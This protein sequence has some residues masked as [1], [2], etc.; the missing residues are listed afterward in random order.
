MEKIKNYEELYAE[1]YDKCEELVEENIQLKEKVSTLEAELLHTERDA[2][3][4][5]AQ[6][7]IIH[8]IFG[9]E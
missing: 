8:E 3:I 5:L 4:M 9:R 6:L 7:S 1:Y 2:E